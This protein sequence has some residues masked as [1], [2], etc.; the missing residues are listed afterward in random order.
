M[1]RDPDS[2]SSKTWDVKC[3]PVSKEEAEKYIR[4]LIQKYKKRENILCEDFWV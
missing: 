4:E 3:N 1:N 2:T